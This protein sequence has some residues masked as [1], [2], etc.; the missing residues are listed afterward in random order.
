MLKKLIFKYLATAI[1]KSLKGGSK[2]LAIT[3]L[4]VAL[5]AQLIGLDFA[6]LADIVDAANQILEG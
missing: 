6:E 3:V 4:V 2:W 1:I 5:V